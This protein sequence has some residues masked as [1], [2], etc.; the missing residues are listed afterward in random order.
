MQLFSEEAGL[1]RLPS[2]D[3]GSHLKRDS[4]GPLESRLHLD[5]FTRFSTSHGHLQ[6]RDTETDRHTHRNRQRH[7][8][9]GT[10]SVTIGRIFELCACNATKKSVQLKR[11]GAAAL[12]EVQLFFFG[13][14]AVMQPSVRIRWLLVYLRPE[15]HYSF[16]NTCLIHQGRRYDFKVGDGFV[17]GKLFDY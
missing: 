14:G 17:T 15:C 9:R 11:L 1:L 5:R 13:G 8:D 12:G 16:A 2:M 7:I 4:L 10:W 6:Q 3:T